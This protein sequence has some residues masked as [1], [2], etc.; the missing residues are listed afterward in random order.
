M[1]VLLDQL[2]QCSVM[3]ADGSLGHLKSAGQS[4]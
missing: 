2:A 1:H 3:R 4:P